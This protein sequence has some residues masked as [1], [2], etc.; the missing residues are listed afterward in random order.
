VKYG[1]FAR[2]VMWLLAVV[3]PGG[4]LVLALWTAARMVRARAAARC[5][6]PPLRLPSQPAQT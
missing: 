4:L 1:P 3:L 6:A 5:A 2:I